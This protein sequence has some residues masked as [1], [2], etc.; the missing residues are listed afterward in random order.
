MLSEQLDK[1]FLFIGIFSFSKFIPSYID[2]MDMKLFL[3]AYPGLSLQ[4]RSLICLDM[5][6]RNYISSVQF[7]LPATRT[8]WTGM[9][10]FS[11]TFIPHY[12][13]DLAVFSPEV[14]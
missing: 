6:H 13:H 11:S 14:V 9:W 5:I 7:E 10:T 4:M 12:L 8:V 2:K 3:V 1:N